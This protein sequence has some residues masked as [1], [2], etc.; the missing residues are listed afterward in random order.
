MLTTS[1]LDAVVES[2]SKFL[3]HHHCA[4]RRRSSSP[5]PES[6][7]Y[8]PSIEMQND[9]DLRELHAGQYRLLPCSK[10]CCRI[11]LVSLPIC[12]E[13]FLADESSATS[14]EMKSA[15][16]STVL[17]SVSGPVPFTDW[18]MT[19]LTSGLRIPISHTILSNHSFLMR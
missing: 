1:S 18:R 13:D 7:Q 3:Q 19:P 10:T 6:G 5:L 15:T 11:R 17:L 12:H 4:I 14:L 16:D 2:S 8:Y 9:P